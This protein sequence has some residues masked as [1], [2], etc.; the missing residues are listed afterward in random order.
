[1][2]ETLP[3]I[4]ALLVLSFPAAAPASMVAQGQR[5]A[6][7]QAEAALLPPAFSPEEEAIF[8]LINEERARHHLPALRWDERVARLARA[9]SA[10][11]R[12]RGKLNHVSP[13]TGAPM[14]RAH[15]AG[16]YPSLLLENIA[17][18][19]SP[20]GVHAALMASPGHRAN[21]LHPD[22]TEIGIGVVVAIVEDG[23]RQIWVTQDFTRKMAP[24]TPETPALARRRVLHLREQAGAAALRVDDRLGHLAQHAA[25]LLAK[26]RLA[27]DGVG[28]LVRSLLPDFGA[29]PELCVITIRAA[30]VSLIG[31]IDALRDPAVTDYGI[32][33][34]AVPAQAGRQPESSA[35]VVL[36]LGRRGVAFG[37]TA[38]PD[39][40]GVGLDRLGP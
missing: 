32:G 7:L 12:D 16:I 31:G 27:R 3:R 36:I 13:Q 21:I 39:G 10:E 11:M 25:D 26:G 38:Y 9:H 40:Q 15:G 1:M 2:K 14:Q 28:G 35:H 17:V 6:P 4:L 37:L 18:A 30:D 34:A 5:P 22:A 33:V 29:Y 19:S 8:N 20:D 23:Q 24:F